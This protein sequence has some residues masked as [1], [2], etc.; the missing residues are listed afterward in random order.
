LREHRRD[1]DAED[2]VAGI[3]VKR[4]PAH[5]DGKGAHALGGIG[6]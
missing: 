6:S 4:A 3:E 1:D 5:R 2:E